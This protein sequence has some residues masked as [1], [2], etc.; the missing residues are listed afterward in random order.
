MRLLQLTTGAIVPHAPLL[1]EPLWSQETIDAAAEITRATRSLDTSEADAVV[2]ISPHGPATGVYSAI[3]GDLAAFGVA[4]VRGKWRT[5]VALNEALCRRAEVELIP[6]GEGIDH[7]ILVPLLLMGVP[8]DMAVVA[9]TA[10]DDAADVEVA[11][12]LATAISKLDVRLGVVASANTAAGLGPR[13]PLQDLPGA[14]DAEDGF[15]EAL[16]TSPG[17]VDE[18]IRTLAVAGG[19]CGLIPLTVVARLFA[20]RPAKVLAH[21]APVGVGYVVA[22]FNA[23]S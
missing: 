17:S 2:V 15:L 12:S 14:S 5:D 8:E 16:T 10:A 23:N 3:D 9:V 11:S 6:E 4:G 1:L 18:S 20:D 22:T 7:G 21:A 19:S 13:A